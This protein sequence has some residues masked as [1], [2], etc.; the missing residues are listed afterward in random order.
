MKRKKKQKIIIT[1]LAAVLFAGS[2][3]TTYQV[4]NHRKVELEKN[5]AEAPH[6]SKQETGMKKGSEGD[7]ALSF[8]EQMVELQAGQF[9]SQEPDA[10]FSEDK[11]VSE[12][13]SSSNAKYAEVDRNTGD[14]TALDSGK[15]KTVTISVKQ[16]LKNGKNISASYQIKVAEPVKS[17]KLSSKKNYVF[18][19]KTLQVK[20]TASPSNA[21]M[22]TLDWSSSNTKY[23][24]V[25]SKG[26]IKPKKEGFG[27][28][29]KIT[30]KTMDG[31]NLKKTIKIRIIDPEK[32]MI[33]MTFDDG[34]SYEN[35]KMV[36]DT[37]K[38]Y[39][40]RATFF[41][42]GRNITKGQTKNREIL[43]EAYKNGNEIGNHS[44]D[45]PNLRKLSANSVKSQLSRTNKLV[46]EVTGKSTTL[47]RPP[48]GETN[49]V[50]SQQAGVPLIF[51]SVD[52][53]DWKTRNIN[54]NVRSVLNGA[55]DGEIILM[56]DIHTPSAKA[57]QIVVPQL[58]EKGYQLVTVSELAEY[59]GLKMKDGQ[60]Y[61][62]VK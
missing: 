4:N 51:W 42:V 37:F 60:R 31:S 26:V 36:V 55:K 54:S 20:A 7:Y 50:V 1:T 14:V 25:N 48:F 44:Y 53:L 62:N 2:I 40:A 58:I 41:V 10:T 6:I 15:G 24:T 30:A 47:L 59:K 38:K 49:S 56:H 39:D 46:K 3:F 61:G 16:R 23:V 13:W 11:V 52:T 18:V 27:K 5:H 19:G 8:P 32:P 29:V 22:P 45:H 35:T 34:P 28:T 9:F 12:D 33:A 21:V 17:I 57:V 43:K